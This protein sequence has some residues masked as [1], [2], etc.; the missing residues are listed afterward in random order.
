MA[1]TI[2]LTR[3][4]KKDATI[5]GNLLGSV[6]HQ[7]SQRPEGELWDKL[8]L[9]EL[10]DGNW[11]TV[12]QRAAP[13]T[14]LLVGD[15]SFIRRPTVAAP[16]SILGFDSEVSTDDEALALM[17]QRTMNVLE[18]SVLAKLLAAKLGWSVIE[19]IR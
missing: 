14:D 8:T 2:K 9:L 17:I 18:W 1:E 5:T 6:R 7:G 4:G 19:D 11:I 10:S 12:V 13:G 15:Y 3:V 16:G